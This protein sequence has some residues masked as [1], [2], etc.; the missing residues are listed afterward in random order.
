MIVCSYEYKPAQKE[1]WEPYFEKE[2]SKETEKV[3]DTA[4]NRMKVS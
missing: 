3:I 4:M 2:I 1:A